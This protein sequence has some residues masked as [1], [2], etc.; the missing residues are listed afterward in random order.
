MPRKLSGSWPDTCDGSRVPP[1]EGMPGAVSTPVAASP[2]AGGSKMR[3]PA[4]ACSLPD[5]NSA[6]HGA[7]R[8]TV[9]WG[10]LHPWEAAMPGLSAIDH[11]VVLMLENRSFDHM[12][13]WLYP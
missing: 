7:L 4:M 13:G 11:V 12:L 3:S 1:A 8:L 2:A 10:L 6:R 9:G 5:R